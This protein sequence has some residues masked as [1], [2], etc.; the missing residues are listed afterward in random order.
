MRRWHSLPSCVYTLVDQSAGAVLLE[1]APG[2][3]RDARLFLHPEKTLVAATPA[4]IPAMLAEIESATRSQKFA[5]G[6][7]GYEAGAAFEPTSSLGAPPADEPLAWFGIYACCHC[8][9]HATGRF[10]DGFSVDEATPAPASAT[11]DFSIDEA[12][13]TKKIEAVHAAIRSGDVYQLNL[14]A[15]F[16]IRI[17]GPAAG[18]YARLRARQPAAYSA[19]VHWQKAR[20]ILSL[21]PEL[22]FHRDGT[23]ITTRPMKGTVARGRTT[24]EDRAQASWLQ[25]DEKNRAENLMI[26]D[27]LRNDLGRIATLGSVQVTELFAVERH[28]T[29]WQMTSTVEA[30]LPTAT[31][32]AT[33]LRALFPCGSITGAPKVRAMQLLNALEGAPRGIY[34]G[35]IGYAGPAGATFNVAIRTL[36]LNGSEATMGVGGGIVI[37]STA[38]S[39]FRECLLKARFL[40]APAAPEFALIESLRWEDGYP[41]LDLHLDRLADSADFFDFF[42]DRDAVREALLDEEKTFGD[43]RPRKVR[44][45]LDRAG[46]IT[47]ASESLAAQPES[48]RVAL[49]KETTDTQD[50][51]LFH[52]TTQRALYTRAFAEAAREGCADV[53]FFN[54]RGELTEGAISNVFLVLDGQWCTPP[55]HCGLLDGVERRHLLATRP[56]IVERVLTRADLERAEAIYLSNAVRGLRRVRLSRAC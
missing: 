15:P 37:D 3:G 50:L 27:L 53:L 20:R 39:E 47:I 35:S 25:N 48:L 32:L 45:L 44:L 52:K 36:A 10:R 19:F 40:T 51:F 55:L 13:Y 7:L 54:E 22:F 16:R 33:I 31:T 8:F 21:S 42:L 5:A 29:L 56:A 23:R 9:D 38:A 26:V 43:A 6:F 41:R 2:T 17:A 12:A 30:E 46:A 49:S 28:P 4:E 14:T 1:S 18:L 34:T 24:A 11:A